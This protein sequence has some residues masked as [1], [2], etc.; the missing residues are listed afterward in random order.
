MKSEKVFFILTCLIVV[1]VVYQ[2]TKYLYNNYYQTSSKDER[3]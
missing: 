1:D 3:K 2:G